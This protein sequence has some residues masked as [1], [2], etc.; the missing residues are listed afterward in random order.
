MHF[1]CPFIV[2]IRLVLNR[3]EM[4]RHRAAI[5]EAGSQDNPGIVRDSVL[6]TYLFQHRNKDVYVV[7]WDR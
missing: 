7:Y 2:G 5:D 6:Y 3:C 4:H 1:C